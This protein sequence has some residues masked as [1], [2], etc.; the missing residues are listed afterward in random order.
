MSSS[1]TGKRMPRIPP[2][3]GKDRVVRR[4][5][6]PAL[7]ILHL[8]LFVASRHAEGWAGWSARW[9]ASS[10]A[11]LAFL[12]CRDLLT[13]RR[14]DRLPDV[15]ATLAW[16]AAGLLELHSLVPAVADARI[17]PAV[18]FPSIAFLL[19]ARPAALYAGVAFAWL[20]LASG[21]GWPSPALAAS[22]GV[23]GTLGLAAGAV[24][25]KRFA[26]LRPGKEMVR[27]AIE[28]S[29]S[30][31]LPWES[32]DPANDTDLA[33]EIG[34]MVPLRSRAELMEGIQRILEGI[35]PVTGADRIVYVHA[36]PGQGRS[37]RAEASAGGGVDPAGGELAVPDDY[38]PVREAILFRRSF[39]SDGDDAR[40]WTIGPS[41]GAGLLSGVAA[42]PVS[43]EGNVEGAILALRFGSGRWT[44]PVGQAL[45]MAAFLAAREIAEAKK[46]YRGHLY[47]VR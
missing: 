36:S 17:V 23:M 18:L 19:P 2:W 38:V 44:E 21:R 13:S 47:L 22:I 6:V 40:Q 34:R 3:Q 27:A 16:G 33:A 4:Y 46:R 41:G 43:I 32:S 9:A 45:E 30:L 14:W 12:L 39:F 26:T 10:F 24:V 42:A 25:R 8:L 7:S 20:S 28:Q 15:P 1:S 11:V 5:A 31:V 29:R 35:L 37:A